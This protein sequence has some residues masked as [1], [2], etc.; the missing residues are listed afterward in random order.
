MK[1]KKYIVTETQYKKLI[2]EFD[3]AQEFSNLLS[4]SLGGVFKNIFGGF[5]KGTNTPTTKKPQTDKTT[6]NQ[7]SSVSDE[8]SLIFQQGNDSND[9]G[10]IFG[11]TPSSNFGAKFL[12]NKSKGLLDGRNVVFSNWENTID[13]VVQKLKSKY[14][15]ANVR[16]VSGFSKGGLRAYPASGKYDFV[17]L[18]DPS[19]EGNYTSVNP[20]GTNT[21]M[22]YDP[23]RTWGLNGLKHA[24]SKLGTNNIIPIKVGHSEQPTEFFKMFKNQI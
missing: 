9:W 2:N 21:K 13:S 7:K 11:G 12:L 16:S 14:P 4:G 24:M 23:R 18:I 6:T 3:F 15:N 17:G 19:I 20:E 5:S 22:I 10:I 8:G 1:P